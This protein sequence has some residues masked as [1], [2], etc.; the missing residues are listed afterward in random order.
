MAHPNDSI[1]SVNMEYLCMVY[2][3][4]FSRSEKTKHLVYGIKANVDQ[5]DTT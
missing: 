4:N 3:F 1:R 2:P 5:P